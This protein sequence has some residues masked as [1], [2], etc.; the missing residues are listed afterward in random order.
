MKNLSARTLGI[1]LIV[2]L[3]VNLF[4]VGIFVAGFFFYR[5]AHHA[6]SGQ[7]FPHWAAR[8]SLDSDARGK[9]KAIWREARPAL[10]MRVRAMRK[11][12]REVRRQ[13]RADPLDRKALDVAYGELRERTI[14]A[15]EAMKDVL[16]K[17]AFTL[18][19]EQRRQYFKHRFRH[20]YR[21]R[22]RPE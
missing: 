14:A 10:R 6:H 7:P 21:R 1:A 8:R 4:L 16:T 18:N 20:R 3:A 5:P 12:R 17:V 15:R 13:L 22:P 11:A 19:A 2:S 9:V